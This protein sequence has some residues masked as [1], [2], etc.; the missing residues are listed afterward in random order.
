MFDVQGVSSVRAT[1]DE[2]R[3]MAGKMLWH[4]LLSSVLKQYAVQPDR[5][6]KVAAAAREER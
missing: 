6:G 3:G 1:R 2:T 4:N 5:H